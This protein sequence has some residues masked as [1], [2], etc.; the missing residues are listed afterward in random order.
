MRTL[1]LFLSVAGL[2]LLAA[3]SDDQA[4]SVLVD[5]KCGE[6]SQWSALI[7]VPRYSSV[8]RGVRTMIYDTVGEPED[9]CSKEHATPSYRVDRARAA[10][11]PR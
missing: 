9:I 5:E 4:T 1:I 8:D 2:A 7:E 6:Q 3:C 11:A 10:H